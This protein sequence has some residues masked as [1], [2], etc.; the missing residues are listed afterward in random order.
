VIS[1]SD[2]VILVVASGAL[3]V[4]IY[5]WHQNT[6]DVSAITIPANSRVMV[7]PA[8]TAV[9]A[10]R[11]RVIDGSNLIEGQ[12]ASQAPTSQV[13]VQTIPEP[14][15]V[16]GIVVPTSTEAVVE[17]VRLGSHQVRAG[18]YLGRIAQQY[19]TDVDTLREINGINGT[20]IQ[21][22]QEILYPL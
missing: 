13:T 19:G 18:D 4:G 9:V 16:T 5:R 20:V 22:G 15:P 1:K 8:P 6:Q 17:S 10:G 14:T 3:A 7:E 21:I 11:T 2:I 12:S